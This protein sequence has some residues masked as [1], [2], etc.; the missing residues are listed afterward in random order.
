M[1]R[2]TVDQL[3]IAVMSEFAKIA[4]V[5]F[6]GVTSIPELIWAFNSLF[7]TAYPE[8]Y[9]ER[10]DPEPIS[11]GEIS[12]TGTAA[13]IGLW[14]LLAYPN[15]PQP[16]YHVIT[17]ID[18]DTMDGG[19]GEL[20]RSKALQHCVVS[21]MLGNQEHVLELFERREVLPGQNPYYLADSRPRE[22]VK[23]L[24]DPFNY[25]QFTS[26]PTFFGNRISTYGFRKERRRQLEASIDK[27]LRQAAENTESYIMYLR[28]IY[29]LHLK[30]AHV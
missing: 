2:S 20:R 6:G 5:K 4:A 27:Q 15:E 17:S 25:R 13:L 26:T 12:C 21:V 28:H 22:A 3:N 1:N 19:I 8:G 10:M 9:K 18:P 23:K 29:N 7:F 24:E 16:I 14:H 11:R 30:G